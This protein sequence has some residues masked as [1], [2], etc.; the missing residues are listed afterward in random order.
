MTARRASS[1]LLAVAQV[2][3][4]VYLIV[5]LYRWQWNRALICGVLF[6]ATE[7]LLI[8][9]LVLQR[10]RALEDR[11]D[12]AA[13]RAP[14]P[15]RVRLVETRPPATDRFAWLRESTTR[16]NVFLPVLL[17][18]GVFASAAAW[19]VE[20]LA[21]RTA[22]P[23]MESALAGDLGRLAFPTGGFLGAAPEAAA[24]QA[25]R[26]VLVVAAAGALVIAIWLFI[27]VLADATQ[28]RPEAVNEEAITLLELHFRGE[29]AVADPTRNAE[30]LVGACTADFRRAIDAI[31]ISELGGGRVRVVLDAD[32]GHDAST[33]LR[34]CLEDTT[35][36][37][38]QANVVSM[39]TIDP[40]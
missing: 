29:H 33:R 34:G 25:R 1:L 39:S 23:A 32:M 24:R 17:G 28:T 11:L 7:V 13:A 38:V 26:K 40:P 14:D 10:L 6:V 8:G 4:G 20:G 19:A 31:G 30:A 36:D 15:V 37:R 2:S 35:I 5:Y 18:A 12:A 16:T 3:T 21:R 22:R 27:D 9:R